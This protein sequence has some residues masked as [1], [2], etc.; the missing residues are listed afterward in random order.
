VPANNERM[1]KKALSPDIDSDFVIFDLE[2][3]VPLDQKVQARALIQKVLT[4]SKKG[5]LGNR[6]QILLRINQL[7]SPLSKLDIDTFSKV[8]EISGFVV[9]K[10]EP[11]AIRGLFRKSDKHFIPIIESASGLFRIE[12]IA[13][14]KGVDAVTYGAAD[15]ALSMKGSVEAFQNNEYVRTTIAVAARSY[16]LDPIDQVYFDLNNF[17]GFRNDALRAKH[18]GYS[19]KLL[20]HPTQIALTNEIF[21]SW[22]AKDKEWAKRVIEAYED[23]VRKGMKK[24]ALR[25]NGQL[26]DAVHYKLAKNIL[27]IAS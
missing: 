1:L 7:D 6:K 27:G 26:I 9:P 21:S 25:L 14:S 2:D 19:G 5:F 4:Q 11:Q 8:E 12:E 13:S 24:G 22:S 3:S 16:G 10:A 18:L 20:I 23:S 17:E 15:M